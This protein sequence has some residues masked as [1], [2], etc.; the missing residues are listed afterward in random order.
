MSDERRFVYAAKGTVYDAPDGGG[1]TLQRDLYFDD[2]LQEG[3]LVPFG[4][5]PALTRGDPAPHWLIAKFISDYR[6]L[7]EG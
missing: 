1:Y 7:S 3:D 6:A 4:G 2:A 5:L